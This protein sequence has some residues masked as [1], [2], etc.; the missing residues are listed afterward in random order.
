MGSD[1]ITVN[2]ELGRRTE[3]GVEGKIY[4]DILQLLSYGTEGSHDRRTERE[5]EGKI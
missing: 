3:R 5:V 2:K 4:C 1:K